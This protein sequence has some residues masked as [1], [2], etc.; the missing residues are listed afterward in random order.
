MT[1]NTNATVTGIERDRATMRNP[2]AT[3]LA[4]QLIAGLTTVTDTIN[5][6]TMSFSVFSEAN[7]LGR[8]AA[9]SIFSEFV[10][11]ISYNSIP[12]EMKKDFPMFLKNQAEQGLIELTECKRYLEIV[13]AIGKKYGLPRTISQANHQ[14]TELAQWIKDEK[15][16]LID[17]TCRLSELSK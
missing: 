3:I 9:Y 14:L 8:V 17:A 5:N 12:W 10:R 13:L 7:E 16:N 1:T 6:E 4:D 15:R 2:Y 11:G